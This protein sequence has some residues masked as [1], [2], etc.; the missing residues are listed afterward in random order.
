MIK[1]Q[2]DI[3]YLLTTVA[4]ITGIQ[5]RKNTIG[6]EIRANISANIIIRDFIWLELEENVKI[7]IR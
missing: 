4:T 7:A 2:G 6:E 3:P 1:K 5:I